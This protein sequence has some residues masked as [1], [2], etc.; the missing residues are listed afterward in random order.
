MKLGVT[1]YSFNDS[2][3]KGKI[4]I[5]GFIDFCGTLGI[6]GLDLISY[7]W[8]DR[9]AEIRK[10]PSLL[11]KN[12]L[13]IVAYGT[14]NNFVYEDE[15]KRDEEIR[16]VKWEIDTAAALE[17]PLMRV[18]GGSYTISAQEN[19]GHD[20][21]WGVYGGHLGPG[22]T[23]DDA[24]ELSIAG[25]RECTDYAEKK[26]VVLALE[27]HGGV[28][29]T[30]RA[31]RRILDAVNSPF[32]RAL[33]DIGNFVPDNQ[34]PIEAM[35]ELVPYAA[36]VHVKDMRTYGKIEHCMLGEGIVD[37]EAIVRLLVQSGYD[38]F[39]SL[40]YEVPGVDEK[41][42]IERSID[43]VRRTLRKAGANK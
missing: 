14:G 39:L 20:P 3:R 36:H 2:Y 34:D 16:R 9:E 38:Q 30:S 31:V 27:N 8:K 35:K 6:Q 5:E 1:M 24:I 15:E 33:V 28:P 10:V 29:G 41:E 32:L 17:A 4:T 22:K 25:L 43:Y 40:E 11:K 23:E 26:G 18:F 12:D 37:L 42:G 7:Y 21:K 19:K 13:A